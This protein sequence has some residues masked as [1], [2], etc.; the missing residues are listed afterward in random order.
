MPDPRPL[1]VVHGVRTLGVGGLEQMVIEH[2]LA[3]RAR[4]QR[5]T[6]DCGGDAGPLAA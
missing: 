2:A 1:H 4:G 5:V 6:V 3:G